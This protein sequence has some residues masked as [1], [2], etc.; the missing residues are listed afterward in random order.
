V[1]VVA[2]IGRGP[3]DAITTNVRRFI[4]HSRGI[5]ICTHFVVAAASNGSEN[6]C[7]H[8]VLCIQV[9]LR[10]AARP[11]PIVF[12]DEASYHVGHIPL[13]A[14][15][16]STL[17]DGDGD[18]DHRARREYSDGNVAHGTLRLFS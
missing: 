7:H 5:I 16:A 13:C 1:I 10:I 17:G 9:G 15:L 3:D 11:P 18:G 2:S 14:S 6:R 8:L 12:S 4:H